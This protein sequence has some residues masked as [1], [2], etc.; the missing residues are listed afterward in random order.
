MVESAQQG[1]L[2]SIG[3][4]DEELD[5]AGGFFARLLQNMSSLQQSTP[6]GSGRVK[7]IMRAAQP[8]LLEPPLGA[9]GVNE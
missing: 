3:K 1:R 5:K 7:P 6:L 9:P 4:A 2:M 8:E